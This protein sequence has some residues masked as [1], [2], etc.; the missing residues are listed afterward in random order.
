MLGQARPIV[1][2]CLDRLPTIRVGVIPGDFHTTGYF[3]EACFIEQGPGGFHF[4]VSKVLKRPK[5]TVEAFKKKFSEGNLDRIREAVR[6][7]AKAYGLAAV[8]EFKELDMYP[9]E[10]EISVSKSHRK[11]LQTVFDQI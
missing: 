4:L 3:A 9:T 8:L 11:P 1:V 2:L 7:G 6:D 5:L 10:A